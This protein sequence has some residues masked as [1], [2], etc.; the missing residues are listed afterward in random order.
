[1]RRRRGDGVLERRSRSRERG[2]RSSSGPGGMA[3]AAVRIGGTG[4]RTDA[5]TIAQRVECDRV[6]WTG[7][8]RSRLRSGAPRAQA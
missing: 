8:P 5:D 2:W 7:N 6:C 3:A 1:V 4:S